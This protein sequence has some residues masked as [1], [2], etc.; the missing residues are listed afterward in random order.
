MAQ[1]AALMP[2]RGT[3]RRLAELHHRRLRIMRKALERST[4]ALWARDGFDAPP[5]DVTVQRV[6]AGQRAAVRATDGYMATAASAALGERVPAVGLNADRLIGAAARGG[7]TLEHAYARAVVAGRESGT[8]AGLDY[9]RSTV[10]T[11]FTLA[12]RLA[13]G[14]L[15]FASTAVVGYR[16]VTGGGNVCARCMSAS[17][18]RYGSDQLQPIHRGCGCS[19][20]PI[21]RT[22][23]VPRT[24]PDVLD[25]IYVSGAAALGAQAAGPIALDGSRFPEGVD[26]EAL[27][28]VNA[29]IDIDLELGP[30]LNA[31]RHDAVLATSSQS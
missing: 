12:Q 25:A 5:I 19:V 6:L 22:G 24:D 7:V 15:M 31:D 4:V 2:E 21:F 26:A 29:R 17:T 23:A 11:D 9:V 30:V 18:Q 14:A 10:A 13:S 28:A 27:A 3:P 16:R 20:A 1:L 8:A